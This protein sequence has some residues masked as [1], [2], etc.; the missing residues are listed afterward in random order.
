ML[1]VNRAHYSSKTNQHSTAGSGDVD[2]Y[3]S[4]CWLMNA[5]RGA[6]FLPPDNTAVLPSGHVSAVEDRLYPVAG[7]LMQCAPL[8][9]T[10]L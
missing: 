6:L 4:K 10:V 5:T 8:F 9:P 1:S 7:C 3:R 2:K